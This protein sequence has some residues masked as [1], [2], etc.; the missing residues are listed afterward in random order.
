MAESYSCN[1]RWVFFSSGACQTLQ[2]T[3]AR[4]ADMFPDEPAMHE[5]SGAFKSISR[6]PTGV[7]A[8]G[9]DDEFLD[10]PF[11]CGDVKKAWLKV[12]NILINDLEANGSIMKEMDMNW[13]DDL[14]RSWLERL[15]LM[16]ESLECQFRI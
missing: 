8:V 16:R 12:M 1:G 14:R 10:E 7:S 13:D 6:Y 5:L 15:S 9:I 3:W 2:L 4:I 11:R